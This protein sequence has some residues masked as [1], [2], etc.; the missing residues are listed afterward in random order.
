VTVTRAIVGMRGSVLGTTSDRATAT[1]GLFC[2]TGASC[3]AAETRIEG[4]TIGVFAPGGA[5]ALRDTVVRDLRTRGS[6]HTIGVVASGSLLAERVVVSRAGTAIVTSTPAGSAVLTDVYVVGDPAP[7]ELLFPGVTE[8]G[9]VVEN[10]AS[11]E[12]DRFAFEGGAGAALSALSWGSRLGARDVFVREIAATVAADE[13]VADGLRAD[14]GG[15][16]D[17]ER[18]VVDDA[19]VAI[20]A[21]NADVTVDALVI[22]A[23]RRAAYANDGG[24]VSLTDLDGPSTRARGSLGLVVPSTYFTDACALF[25]CL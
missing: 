22:H 7:R 17:A 4:A 6:F 24:T 5:V 19:L 13:A 23:P 16:I 21:T 8:R 11:A 3:T 12:V 18:V 1:V 25:A 10:G 14:T 20:V 15:A 9:L 2:G